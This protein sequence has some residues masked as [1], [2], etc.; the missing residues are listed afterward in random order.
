MDELW[1]VRHGHKLSYNPT[2]WLKSGRFQENPFDDPLSDLGKLTTSKCGGELLK[3]SHSKILKIYC[4][5][6]TRCMQTAVNIIKSSGWFDMRIVVDYDLAESITARDTVVFEDNKMKLVRP[7][8]VP[9]SGTKKNWKSTIDKKM[10]PGHL[11]KRFGAYIDTYEGTPPGI[12]TSE[13]ES[14]RMF[15]AVKKIAKLPGSKIIVGHAHTLDIAYN[16]LSGKPP[17]PT[18]QFGG[19]DHVNTMIGFLRTKSGHK[20]IYKP[21]NKF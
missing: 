9:Y 6:F 2:K 1:V 21:N 10:M 5:P 12:E 18:Y 3:R 20:I 4:S 7:T 14:K 13:Q 15:K 19:P 17:I 8:S 16:Y 11:R